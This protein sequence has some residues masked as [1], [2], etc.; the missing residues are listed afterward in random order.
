MSSPS[1]PAFRPRASIAELSLDERNFLGRGQQLRMS[2][3]FGQNEQTYNIS[4]TDPV[5]PRPE[6][7]GR[8]R[9]LQ[10]RAEADVLPPL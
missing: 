6:H 4:F 8:C 10:D 9:R 1:A 2:V 7:V 3:G 5:F